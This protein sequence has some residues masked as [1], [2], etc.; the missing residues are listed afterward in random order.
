[1]DQDNLKRG[2]QR[3]LATDGSFRTPMLTR[4]ADQLPGDLT[5][6]KSAFLRQYL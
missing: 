6:L 1:M 4:G 3:V 2:P 5:H